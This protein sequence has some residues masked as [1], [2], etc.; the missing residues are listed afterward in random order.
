MFNLINDLV[1]RHN[2]FVNGIF[3]CFFQLNAE[4]FWSL[5]VQIPEIL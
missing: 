3:A 2:L 1:I 5:A 4:L